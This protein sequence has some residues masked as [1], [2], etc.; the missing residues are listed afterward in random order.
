L[1]GLVSSI[2]DLLIA[3]GLLILSLH[4]SFVSIID[5]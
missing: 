1:I 3:I 4:L 5:W 2:T